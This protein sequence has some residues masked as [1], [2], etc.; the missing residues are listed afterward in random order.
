MSSDLVMPA[1]GRPFTLGMLYDARREKLIPGFS[2]FGDETL[3]KYQSSN[4]QRSSEFKIVA[5]DSTESKSS[6]MDIEA[7]LGVSF[8][9]GLVEVGGS[10]KYL[11]NTKKYQNQSRVTLKYKA[12]TVYKQFTAPPGTVTVQETAITE[13]GLATHVVTSIL[14]GANAFFVSDSDKVEDTNLQDIQGKMEAAIKKIPTISIE[15]SASVQ[16]TD[17]EKSLAS[18]L[19]CKFHGDFLLESLPTTF[20][21]AVKTY[22]TLPTLIGEDGANSVPM[23]VWLAPLKSYNSKA[24]QLIQEIN[25]SKVR[26]IHTTL[27]ELHK[28]K[29]RANEAMDVKLVQRI[30]L[31]HDKISNF[32]QIFQDYMLTV[33]KKIAEKLPLV[34]AGTES[35]QS[36]QKIIDDRAQ[37]PFSNEKVSKW[38][39]AVEREIAV[40]KSCAGMVEGTQAKFVSNQTELDRE[41]LVGK[42]KHAVCFIFTSVERNDPYLKVLSDYWE[43]PPSNN[44]KDVA[45]STEDKWCFSTE[46]VLKMQ[47]RAQTFCDHVNDFEKSRNVGFFITALE[48]GKFQGASIYYYKEGSL[49]TQDFTFPRMPFVQGYKKR[50]DLLWYACDLTFDRNTINNWISLSD[51]DT[52]AASEHGKRQNYPKHPERFVSF[53]QVL[54]N[55]GLMGKHYWEVEWN[56][57]IDVGIAYISI[58]RKEI[59]F[60]SAFGYNTYSWVLSY[61]P[62][63]GYIERH[64]KRE[65]NVR[66]PNPGFKRLGLFLDWR[67]G[68]ISF[69]AVSSDEVHHLHTFKTKF[70]EPV[71]PAFSIGPAG[72]HGTLRLL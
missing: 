20:E 49:A 57:Y 44:A 61:N 45:P 38:L 60:A 42:V 52:F 56:G 62:K 15:G 43:S 50:S 65:Y 35:E 33:Q 27:E 3:Q 37:S 1:L 7:S 5:S 70:T 11:N 48:N 21:D 4:A 25:V 24:Q 29:R 46:V 32:Q 54:C 59:D 69:Y 10:A 6:A 53:N 64:K 68:S 2:L 8:L 16:L 17:E 58:P 26:R 39:D 9:G 30:P 34:R 28:L 19:S 14:Y 18:N 55:E 63:I 13:K 22:Q 41:V 66:A 23:K 51:N 47:Q 40:L 71:Y 67:Y 12:T 72:N 31:I 36:L